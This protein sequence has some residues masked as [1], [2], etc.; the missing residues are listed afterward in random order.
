MSRKRN[1]APGLYAFFAERPEEARRQFFHA[2]PGLNRRGFF[3]GA[4]STA[5]GGC[6]D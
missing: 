1:E 4:G 5:A 3:I 2:K 6:S